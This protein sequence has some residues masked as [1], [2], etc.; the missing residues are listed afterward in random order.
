MIKKFKFG[1]WGS[2]FLNIKYSNNNLLSI[3]IKTDSSTYGLYR[4]DNNHCIRG[5][6]YDIDHRSLII[7][8]D[9]V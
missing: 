2:D 5:T 8:V 7:G 9:D 1:E 4:W 6:E 3:Y